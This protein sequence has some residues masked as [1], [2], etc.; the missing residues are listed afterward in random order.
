M[1]LRITYRPAAGEPVNLQITAD[2]TAT[3]GDVARALAKGPGADA[4]VHDPDRLT[5]TVSDRAG[6]RVAL[7]PAQP[8]ISSELVSGSTVEL[9]REARRAPGRGE[10]VA[11]LRVVGGP[12]A[13]VEVPLP[14]GESTIGRAPDCHVRLGDPL[15]SKHHARIEIRDRVEVVDTNS[16]NGV[17]VG[18]VRVARVVVGAGDVVHLGD[19][20]VTIDHTRRPTGVAATSTDIAFVRPPRVLSR[21]R[22]QAVELPRPPGEPDS[23]RF[24]WLAMV[25]PLIMGAV[26]FAVTRNALSIAFVALSPILMLGNWLGQRSES[27]R[28]AKAAAEGFRAQLQAADARLTDLHDLERRQLEALHPT[29]AECVEA[30]GHLG[31]A[32][33]SRRPEHPEFLHV[34]L[35]TGAIAPAV[36]IENAAVPGTPD[37]TG[38]RDEVVRTY[39]RLADA[40][41]VTDLRSVGGV[42]I[43]GV[44]GLV[45][46]VARALVTQVVALHSPA[47][48]VLTCLTS[49]AGRARWSWVEWLPHVA[50]PH[51]PIGSLQLSSDPG[52]GRLLLDRLEELV[53]VRRGENA[54]ELRGPA[55]AEDSGTQPFLPSVVL[56]VDEPLV[57]RGRL[58]RLA[59]GG[60]DVGVHVVWVA[61]DRR[62]LP[63][64]C[65]TYLDVGDGASAKAG[66]VRTGELIAPVRCES[67]DARTAV[68]VSRRL[69]AVVD[70]GAPI[71]DESDVPRS[72]ALLP[73]LGQDAVDDPE[74][75]LARWRENGSW[76]DRALPAHPRERHG[77]LR[78]VV[79]HTGT[80]PFTL[81]LRAQGPHA[82][83]GGTTG[84]GKSEFL[85]AWVLALA[86][87]NSPDR[88]TFLFVDYKGG[89]AFA[90][91]VDLPHTVGMVTDL[92]PYLVRRALRSLRAEIHHREVLLQEKGV[93]DLIDFEL[94]GDP[95]CPPSLII[96][97]DE[98]AALAGEVPEFVDGVIDVAQ[99]GR[100]LGL[101]LVMATQRP[102]G[103][104]RDSLRANT[105]LRV[106][107]RVNDDHDSADVLGDTMAARFDPS[108]PGR[109][110]ARTGPARITQFQS[111]FP[112][113][114]TTAAP[115]AP[116]IEIV[117]LDF[118]LGRAWKVA[119]SEQSGP[120]PPKDIERVVESV[121]RAAELG[122]VPAPRRPWLDTLAPAYNLELLGQR[123]DTDLVLGVMDDPDHQTQ[124]TQHFRPDDDGNILFVGSGGSGKTTALRTIAI[125]AGFVPRGGPVH[126][127][128]LD[129]SGGGLSMLEPLPYVG[130]IVPADDEE[131]VGRLMRLLAGMIE[132]REGRYKAAGQ[133]A[134]ITEYR[135]NSGRQGEPRVLLLLD[136]FQNFRAEY[137]AS[138]QRSA[139]Y[140]A[141]QKILTQGRPVGL[142]VAMTVDRSPSVPN[143]LAATFQ[144][145]VILRQT[146]EDGYLASGVPKDVLGPTSSPGRAMLVDNPQELQLAILGSD[147]TPGR[148]AEL[149]SAMADELRPFFTA[150]PEAIRSLPVNVPGG[151][152][153][154]TA[155]DQPVLGLEDVSLAPFGFDPRGPVV[156]AGPP[157][158]G[159][160]TAFRWLAES[161]RR[162]SPQTALVHLSA[163]PSALANLSIWT[164]S[165][166]GPAEVQRYVSEKLKPYLEQP[167]GSKPSVAVFVEHYPEFGASVAEM[168]LHEAATLARRNGHP[169]FVEGEPG[170]FGGFQGFLSEVR[171]ARTGLVLQ[172]DQNDGD[173]LFR[174]P[175]PRVRRAD[176][177]PGRG[178]W[179][180]GG[181]VA[182][183]QLPMPGE[184]VGQ[185]MVK[186]AG[187][188]DDG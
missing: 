94:T 18:G 45:D 7:A 97:V 96:V 61:P 168:A 102:A 14:A 162:W 126:V 63:A 112:G 70:V 157:Q 149:I 188:R 43:S 52:T 49:A 42:G 88:V 64:A 133:A 110:A 27:K 151:S 15:V 166:S 37:F 103:V 154:A 165:M 4:E 39:A 17:V 148:Q 73:L 171:Q 120:K 109:A 19:S 83:V 141:F 21:R 75:V 119:A 134:S 135:R 160:T 3:A 176:F 155:G 169:L 30:I 44:A 146:D 144:K 48:V 47:E 173:N 59:E 164:A 69:A 127:Y 143:A 74:Q 87:A 142:H 178:L 82:L 170:G 54:P 85:Q 56:I 90:R 92:S 1:K 106:A 180:K 156:V 104:I 41:V 29:V 163:R 24:P 116:P 23:S 175:F 22:E 81:D 77:D 46:G 55:D 50:S 33:W 78:A 185:P 60:P 107:L 72:V 108:I 101:H 111:A 36:T 128:G 177:P 105:N 32:L 2:A 167:A 172:P 16:A 152:L 174:T 38:P 79:G 71:L 84:S 57:D 68:D 12:D 100:S 114:R 122:R 117:E 8:I 124:L 67:I 179:V 11:L 25:A 186:V 181:R 130:S 147:G 93:K 132:E 161:V 51:S 125:A 66:M 91:C 53:T 99:R 80:E 183:V 86:H 115:L 98:F 159:R 6:R 89:A 113:A 182:K 158:S 139:T 123:T 40:A 140:N 129:F 95:T 184:G 35:G 118:G 65:R 138:V 136:G 26:M 187:A 137:D 121:R 58:T 10:P 31:D 76:V 5:L 131:R 150:R 28:K 9:S 153:P 13:G 62:Q 145:K 20:L 34:R